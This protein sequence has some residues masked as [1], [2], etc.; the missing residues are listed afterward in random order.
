MSGRITPRGGLI[1]L[2]KELKLLF[3]NKRRIFILTII[4]IIILVMGLITGF[5]TGGDP[6]TDPLGPVVI[7]VL[8][9]N[10]SNV[11][12]AMKSYWE[13]INNTEIIDIS[14]DYSAV[15]NESNFHVLVYIP[16][17]FTNLILNENISSVEIIYN[18][19]SS[20]YNLV[21]FQV[22]I[23]TLVF[24]DQLIRSNNPDVAFELIE[25]KFRSLNG[26][27][28]D[29]E[30]DIS[31]DLIG[32]LV[33]VPVYII[34]FVI[35]TPMSLILISV[36]IEREQK[37]LETL[38]LQPVKRRD[39]VLGKVYYG[40]ALVLITIF[41]DMLALVLAVIIFT[42][43]GD[44]EM[45]D[46]L[47]L[48]D[49]AYQELGLQVILGFLVALL[50]IA[51]N[52]IAF[53][54]LLSLVAKDEREANMISGILPMLIFG[55]VAFIFIVPVDEFSTIYQ[56]IW[57]SLPVIGVIIVIYL[58][59]LAGSIIWLAYLSVAAQIVWAYFTIN[60]ITKISEAESIIELS[61]GALFREMKRFIFRR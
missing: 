41:L 44:H 58:S 18:I 35:I 16:S 21:A 31:D 36:T 4:P 43:F 48:M 33:V 52:I 11:T 17:N 55:I 15:V 24:E 32:L 56:V 23:Q 45:S 38:F 6:D 3:K 13:T 27:E 49:E 28:N 59:G 53:A 29:G 50:V 42:S 2:E 40:M 8:D 37:T 14:G 61:Y 7:S 47:D 25:P 60:F 39:I 46:I 5:T 51:V 12:Q 34:I 1:L 22:L 20:R 26:A 54:I 19:N 57:V 30:D 10:P 9:E